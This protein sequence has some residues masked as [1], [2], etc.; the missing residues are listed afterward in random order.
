MSFGGG[1]QQAPP[2]PPVAATTVPLR[3]LTETSST[4]PSKIRNFTDAGAVFAGAGSPSND[5]TKPFGSTV[6]GGG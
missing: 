6:L 1:G 5:P 4:D 2:P 3:T